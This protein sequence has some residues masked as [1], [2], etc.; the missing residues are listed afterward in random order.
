MAQ[1]D[2]TQEK[3]D[4]FNVKPSDIVFLTGSGISLDSGLPD[5]A[6]FVK[7]LLIESKTMDSDLAELF[8]R[9]QSNLL[10]IADGAH[11]SAKSNNLEWKQVALKGLYGTGV[12]EKP[13]SQMHKIVARYQF[14]FS[15]PVL[16]TNFDVLHEIAGLKH[17]EH[18]V[19]NGWNPDEDAD[20]D[21]FIPKSHDEDRHDDE[22]RI[23]ISHLHGVLDPR[24]DGLI[25]EEKSLIIGQSDYNNLFKKGTSWQSKV[26]DDFVRGHKTFVVLG[27]SLN[28]QDIQNWFHRHS[29]DDFTAY[30]F[31][32]RES[33]GVDKET[34]ERLFD[35]I[36]QQWSSINVT[37]I[38]IDDY[39]DANQILLEVYYRNKEGSN[40]RYN[41]P[42]TRI[43]CL[44]SKIENDTRKASEDTLMWIESVEKPCDADIDDFDVSVWIADGKGSIHRF[45]SLNRIFLKMDPLK[46][47]ETGFDSEYLAG[48][49]ICSN[50]VMLEDGSDG[51]WNTVMARSFSCE[52]ADGPELSIGVVTVAVKFKDQSSDSSLEQRVYILEQLRV[53]I[54][55]LREILSCEFSRLVSSL[56]E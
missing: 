38:M 55:T 28:D 25:S 30:F 33:L 7:N 47:I 37:T 26:I 22:G 24:P 53:Y 5:W 10:V 51:K 45:S 13:A 20:P 46:S 36:K 48:R 49:A 4:E 12:N 44:Y 6:T 31:V 9:R 1:T 39:V 21:E 50:S 34:F 56:A 52:F 11:Q 41:P 14:E 27:H 43:S 15:C 16:T 32:A 8:V 35:P 40:N 29:E 42:A 3:I 18:L 19:E 23:V 17:L 2:I 54:D